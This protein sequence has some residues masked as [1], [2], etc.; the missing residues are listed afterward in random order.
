[1][2]VRSAPNRF[3]SKVRAWVTAVLKH[4]NA[5]Q[6]NKCFIDIQIFI[7][8]KGKSTFFYYST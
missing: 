2:P 6:R 3:I 7:D 8:Y 1:M 5:M 4:H